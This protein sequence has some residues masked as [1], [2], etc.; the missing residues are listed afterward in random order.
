MYKNFTESESILLQIGD[1]CDRIKMPNKQIIFQITAFSVWLSVCCFC[2]QSMKGC[3]FMKKRLQ[4]LSAIFLAALIVFSAA[5][6]IALPVISAGAANDGIFT[7]TVK[8]GKAIITECDKNAGGAI[9]VPSTLGGYPVTEIGDFAFKS[10]ENIESVVIPDSVTKICFSAFRA[11]SKLKSVTLGK[12]VALIDVYAFADCTSL[13]SI[14]IPDSA[15]GIGTDSFYNCAFYND[16]NNWENGVFYIGNHLIKADSEQLPINYS[17]KDGTVEIVGL[18]FYYCEELESIAIP[19]T[20]RKIGDYAFE[21][22]KKLESINFPNGLKSIGKLAFYSC[23]ALNSIDIPDSV[24]SIGEAAFSNCT[25]VQ[26]LSISNNI[27]II[28]KKAFAGMTNLTDIAIPSGVTSIGEMAFYGAQKVQ[29]VVIPEGVTSLG[30]FAFGSCTELSEITIPDS[31][32]RIESK[33]VDNTPLYNDESNWENGVLYI[34]NHLIEADSKQLSGS[35]NIKD[36]TVSIAAGA[37]LY[38]TELQSVTIPDTIKHIVRSTFLSC[39]GLTDVTI[40]SGVESIEETA[41]QSCKSLE[42]ITIPSNVKSIGSEA[43]SYCDKLKNITL[44]NGIESIAEHAFLC[45]VA[46]EDISIPKS[47]TSIGECPFFKCTGLVNIAVDGENPSFSSVDG[48]LFNKNKTRLIEYPIG[49]SQTS[50]SVPNGVTEIGAKAFNECRHLKKISLPEGITS[51]GSD[52]FT[53]T[54][55]YENAQNGGNALIYID[56]YL[57]GLQNTQPNEC[58]IKSGTV[59]I[60]D[61]VFCGS[62]IV[63]TVT[64]PSSVKYIGKEAFQYCHALKNIIYKGDKSQ[65]EQIIIGE[66]NEDLFNASWSY[67]QLTLWER[68]V[69]FFRNLFAKLFGR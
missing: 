66:G 33:L 18:A 51:I 5:P 49:K 3:D 32:T 20:V 31:V 7:Y 14:T 65:A 61:S 43:L 36:G 27:E 11:C 40:G 26:S 16:P 23:V 28:E 4:R 12:N 56:N 2:L 60:A 1:C 64:I 53:G 9:T 45:D 17:V 54:A 34:G 42:A 57:I 39:T 22:C 35:Y 15:T 41:F 21:H 13:S 24:T 25:A 47:V 69:E 8:D 29:S 63:E 68:I 59:L 30:L 62:W 46:L 55:F 38:C 44:S 58:E 52:A 10:C 6:V 37:F 67:R 48:V 19:S 50:Y